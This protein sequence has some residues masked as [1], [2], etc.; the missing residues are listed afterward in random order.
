MSFY[1]NRTCCAS[2]PF[3]SLTASICTVAVDVVACFIIQTVCTYIGAVLSI[4][5]THAS[6]NQINR[7]S[8]DKDIKILNADIKNID[9]KNKPK[10]K[11]VVK[12]S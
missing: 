10:T 7:L 4:I 8:R 3:K 5:P 6:Y 1:L 2:I 9:K 11:F 12:L